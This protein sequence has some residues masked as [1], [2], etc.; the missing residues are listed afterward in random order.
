MP[1]PS[2]SPRTSRVWQHVGFTYVVAVDMKLED[3]V[4]AG[5]PMAR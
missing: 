3:W 5:Y 4:K 2:R 1:V